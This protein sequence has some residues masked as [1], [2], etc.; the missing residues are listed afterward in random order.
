MRSIY[1]FSLAVVLLTMVPVRADLFVRQYVSGSGELV[2]YDDQTGYHWYWSL[3]DFTNMTYA[4]QIAKID[5]LDSYGN[6]AGGWHLAT[7]DEMESL[8]KYDASV[9]GPSFRWT[10]TSTERRGR[11]E[12]VPTA[13]LHEVGLV[14]YTDY[15]KTWFKSGL[16]DQTGADEIP[17]N[18]LGAWV[19]SDQ[20]VVPLPGAV[21]L[22]VIGLC[23]AGVK[24]RKFI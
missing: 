20:A 14:W 16:L 8:W 17:S 12:S 24:L 4:E 11:F 13:G 7:M 15:W 6:I 2:T 10:G 19:V 18:Y 22:G 1:F 23:A 3:T 21:L 9:I 5:T